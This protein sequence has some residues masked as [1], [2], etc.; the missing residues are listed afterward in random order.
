[1]SSFNGRIYIASFLAVLVGLAASANGRSQAPAKTAATPDQVTFF[2]NS[3]RPVFA[4]SC[5]AC[6][7]EGNAGGGLRLDK[8]VTP[9]QAT[10]IINRVQGIGGNRMPQGAPP[11][12]DEK[13][14]ALL[15]WQT[16]G[17]VWPE[18]KAAID[19]IGSRLGKTGGSLVHQML[20]IVYGSISEVLLLLQ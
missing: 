6:H 18:G 8:A 20:L 1:M 2:E 15:A 12:K 16:N 11:L 9:A 17:A 5:V 14:K 3:V 7:T 10:A 4:E 19:G 13:L